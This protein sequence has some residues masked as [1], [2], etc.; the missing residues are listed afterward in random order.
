MGTAVKL[1]AVIDAMDLPEE[2]ESLIDPET[3]QIV[4]ISEDDRFVL[5]QE[6]EGEDVD[7]CEWQR[8]SI[9]EIRKVLDSGRAIALPGK[10]DIHEWDLMRRFALSVEDP[11]ASAEL[12]NAIHGTGAFRLFRMTSDRLGM[13]DRWFEYRAEALREIAREWL[14]AHGIEYVEE[15]GEG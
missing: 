1:E 8:E 10:F 13:R 4:T 7:T 14:E 2:W 12:F 3:G 9:A 6:D 15:G 11:D 5:D